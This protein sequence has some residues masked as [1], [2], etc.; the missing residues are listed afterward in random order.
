MSSLFFCGLVRG[1]TWC[2]LKGALQRQS[3]NQSALLKR[4]GIAASRCFFIFA[5]RA[6]LICLMSTCQ[7]A[8]TENQSE[9]QPSLLLL[10]QH[11]DHLSL[12]LPCG[13]NTHHLSALMRGTQRRCPYGPIQ[14]AAWQK[15]AGPIRSPPPAGVTNLGQL[16]GVCGRA[17]EMITGGFQRASAP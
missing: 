7:S 11:S 6:L 9:T 10:L 16:V 2:D 14:R 8:F 13:D 3:E 12:P 4:A 17:S 1:A 15:H 5:P